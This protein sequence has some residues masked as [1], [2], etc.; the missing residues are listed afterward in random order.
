MFLEQINPRSAYPQWFRDTA[1]G[2]I[3]NFE[4]SQEITRIPRITSHGQTFFSSL[5]QATISPECVPQL[6][7]AMKDLEPQCFIP[8]EKSASSDVI[9]MAKAERNKKPCFVTI[10]L[11][12][13]C[14]STSALSE[15]DI[16]K[17]LFLFERLAL[18][19]SVLF[20]F[21]LIYRW[22]FATFQRV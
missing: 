20:Q 21:T 4:V 11:A 17:E 8:L 14:F 2:K 12:A 3:D 5:N 6:M 1:F 7:Q 22:R 16:S 10:G 18:V 19:F 13:K 15:T 9:I